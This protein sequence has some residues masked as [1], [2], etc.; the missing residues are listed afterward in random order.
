MK[1]WPILLLG[2]F[3]GLIVGGVIFLVARRPAGES[4]SLGAT[5]TFP[6]VVVHVAGAVSRPGVYSLAPASRVSAALEAAGGALEYADLQLLNLAA[7]LRDGDR[8][9]V[10]AQVTPTPS[11][12]PGQ[13]PQ[14]TPRPVK[15]TL[16]PPSPEHPLNINTATLE[17]FDLLPGIGSIKADAILAYRAAN[18]PFLRIDDLLKVEGITPAVF[19]KIKDLV[20]VLPQP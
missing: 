1:N 7:P 12:E 16:V 2:I 9:W 17:Q 3:L 14:P 4:I 18:G 13:T 8:V 19:A 15:V 10:P 20:S 6:P 11:P 5:P